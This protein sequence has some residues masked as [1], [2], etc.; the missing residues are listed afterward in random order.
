[1]ADVGAFDAFVAARGRG[2]IGSR[3]LQLRHLKPG[4]LRTTAATA[5]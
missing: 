4:P 5:A 2:M 3:A 1:M